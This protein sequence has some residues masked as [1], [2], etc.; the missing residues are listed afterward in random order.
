MFKKFKKYFF[1]NIDVIA[2]S[3]A[4]STGNYDVILSQY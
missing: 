3:V 4:A 2:A 1:D